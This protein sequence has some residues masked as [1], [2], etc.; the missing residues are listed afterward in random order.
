MYVPE[1]FPFGERQAKGYMSLFYFHNHQCPHVALVNL[2]GRDDALYL[3]MGVS[4]GGYECAEGPRV[5]VADFKDLAGKW[6]RFE[7]FIRWADDKSG[8]VE[9]YIDGKP[10]AEWDGVTLAEGLEDVNY[11]KFGIY[12]CCTNDVANVQPATLY[13]AAVKR[14]DKRDGLFTDDDR[15]VLRALQT[16]LNGLGC[17]VGAADGILG[18][19]T[20]AMALSCRAFPDGQLPDVLS[21]GTVRQFVALYS[22]PGVADLPRGVVT[23]PPTE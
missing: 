19:K 1:D 13:Y 8:Q 14:A 2:A 3:E 18:K 21:V 11:T 15:E 4:L 23:E 22:A 16:A 12:L 20:R 7:L 10:S 9:V 6:S 5:K 17:D